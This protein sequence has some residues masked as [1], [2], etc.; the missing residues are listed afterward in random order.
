VDAVGRAD[1]TYSQQIRDQ[2]ENQTLDGL[3]GPLRFSAEEHSG[4]Q[5]EAL[6]ILTV[7]KGRWTLAA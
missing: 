2:L 7:Q 3:S 4:L 5:P 6:G 1:S